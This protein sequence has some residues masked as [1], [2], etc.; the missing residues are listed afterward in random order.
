[1]PTKERYW[2]DKAKRAA[3]KEFENRIGPVPP[4]IPIKKNCKNPFEAV[5]N[6]YPE[7]LYF[8]DP[9]SGVMCQHENTGKGM[10]K[11]EKNKGA[12]KMRKNKEIRKEGL[13]LDCPDIYGK[14]GFTKK[15]A[16]EEGIS[17]RTVQRYFKEDK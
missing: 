12:K 13:K 11:G 15:I 10:N 17:V 4:Y 7:G 5:L 16:A 3:D 14:R 8:A 1:M 6:I 2:K 9:T